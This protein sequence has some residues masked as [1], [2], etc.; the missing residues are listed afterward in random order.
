MVFDRP[1]TKAMASKFHFPYNKKF[2]DEL[3]FLATH[4]KKFLISE[5]FPFLFY[6]QTT[7]RLKIIVAD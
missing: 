5:F 4:G 3:M 2:Q 7:L 6:L 1:V